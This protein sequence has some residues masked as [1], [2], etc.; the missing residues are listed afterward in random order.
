MS[1][2]ISSSET[3]P[4]N[5]S[6]LWLLCR[7]CVPP[8]PSIDISSPTRFHFLQTPATATKPLRP[9]LACQ[10]GGECVCGRYRTALS[11]S[12]AVGC[13]LRAPVIILCPKPIS[14]RPASMTFQ[15]T[16]MIPQTTHLRTVIHCHHMLR[17]DGYLIVKPAPCRTSHCKHIWPLFNTKC[18][19]FQGQFSILSAFS[20]EKF[21]KSWHIYCNSQYPS[22][23]PPYPHA[24]ARPQPQQQAPCTAPHTP[25]TYPSSSGGP[26]ASAP[27]SHPLAPAQPASQRPSRRSTPAVLPPAPHPQRRAVAHC[28]RCRTGR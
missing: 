16:I 13:A 22:H 3:S 7:Q 24:A 5:P 8:P 18:I 2:S 9:T 17:H 19:V 28:G 14:F 11:R 25:A 1:R 15:C 4:S 10:C 6:G 23:P 27:L 21:E 20:T 12:R 26:R